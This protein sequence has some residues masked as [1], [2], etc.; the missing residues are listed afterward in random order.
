MLIGDFLRNSAARAPD[1]VALIGRGK[2]ITYAE[3]EQDTNRLANALAGLGLN[4]GAKVAILSSNCP[5]YAIV[6]FAV[7]KTPY[8]SAHCSTRS[9]ATDLALTI[10]R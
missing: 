3:F 4:K 6:Y 5:E 10:R 7:A 1:R 8:I 2:R 9:T